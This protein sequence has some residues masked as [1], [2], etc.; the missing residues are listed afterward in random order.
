MFVKND[1]ASGLPKRKE[2]VKTGSQKSVQENAQEAP[3]KVPD[4]D[5]EADDHRLQPPKK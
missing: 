2:V 1:L 3:K 4:F 5:Q